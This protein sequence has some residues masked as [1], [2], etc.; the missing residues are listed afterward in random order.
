MCE[1]CAGK[2]GKPCLFSLDG[3]VEV[4]GKLAEGFCGDLRVTDTQTGKLIQ[5]KS[6]RMGDGSWTQVFVGNRQT[7]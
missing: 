7:K 1:G 2:A 6:I 5:G 3:E 4:L